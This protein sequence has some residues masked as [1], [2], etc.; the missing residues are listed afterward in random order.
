MNKTS[1]DVLVVGFALFAM[2]FGAGNLIFPPSLGLMSG[3]NWIPSLI[4]FLLTGI[5][6]PLLG[7]IA[8]SKAGG[9]LSDLA[10]KVSP[11]FS[12]ILGTVI[13]LA[14]GPLLAIPRTGA[15]TFE[16]GVKPLF[17]GVSPIITSIFF[18]GIT[19][20]LAINPSG[21]VDKIGKILTPVL[22]IALITI[23]FKG[24]TSPIGSP[25][26]TGLKNPFSKGFTEGYQTMDALASMVFAGI[27]I[28]SLVQKGYTDT[29]QQ[30]KLTIMSG[31]V[32]AIG[33]AL[34]YG[35][36]M[37]LGATGSGVFPGDIAKTD[38]T[39]AITERILGNTGKVLIGISV[40]L[41]CLTTS[42]GLTATCGEY[43]SKLSKG[44]L[45][46][47]AVAIIVT[48][49]SAVVSNFGV[50]TIV[51]IA[52][53]L[54]V[55]VYPVGIILIVMNIFDDFIPNKTAYTGAVFGALCV[56]LFDALAAMEIQISP[57]ANVILKLP[58]ADAG[59][60]WITPAVI[61]SIISILILKKKQTNI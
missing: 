44:K 9:S 56:S 12:K 18:F 60:A 52:V 16:M 37:Y 34:V 40:S 53:P 11:T 29:K 61:G 54:L 39:I 17:P 46:Y 22:L 14:I 20:F 15:T 3:T 24:I 5:G 50:E 30:I 45:S 55:T 51:K 21:V 31:L 23:I 42:V 6:M 57:I 41:A 36:L 10:D 35:G 26:D 19:L 48:V 59:F 28:G 27:V 7:I 1:K 58:L 38:L 4:G 33:L 47:K 13:M 8:A 49:F 32:A 25:I 43:F 2:F